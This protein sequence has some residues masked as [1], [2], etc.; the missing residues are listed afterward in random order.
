MYDTSAGGING[1]PL[2]RIKVLGKTSI[3]VVG[4]SCVLDLIL[5]GIYG[6]RPFSV[7]DMD[8]W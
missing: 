2:G 8:I 4:F 6:P 1:T 7:S 3:P 5:K